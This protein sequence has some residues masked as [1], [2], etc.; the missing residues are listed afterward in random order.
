MVLETNIAPPLD[1]NMA[2][3][4]HPQRQDTNEQERQHNEKFQPRFMALYY[5]QFLPLKVALLC[6]L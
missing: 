1:F 5:H 4:A 2:S 6:E 3:M